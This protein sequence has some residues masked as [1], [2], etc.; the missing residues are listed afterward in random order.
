M[1]LSEAERIALH[2]QVSIVE[3]SYGLGKLDGREETLAQTAI[4][5]LSN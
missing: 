5:M 1:K 3:S 4:K 2:Y